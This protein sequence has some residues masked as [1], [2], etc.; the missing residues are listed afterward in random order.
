MAQ[1]T[2]K[3]LANQSGANFR[4]ELNTIL[5][6]IASN[7]SGSSEPSGTPPLSTS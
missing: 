3:N 5:S 4:S 6:A 2:D 1:S 7:N